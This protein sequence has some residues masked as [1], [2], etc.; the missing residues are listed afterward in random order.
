MAVAISPQYTKAAVA[1]VN[2][3]SN[4]ALVK[5]KLFIDNHF[6]ETISLDQLAA[7]VELN[8]FTLAK[9]FRL[10]F[11]VSP[12]R[13]LCEVRVRHAQS[14][15]EKGL[16]PTDIASEVGFFDQSH[17]IRHFKRTCGMTP[18]EYMSRRIR[19]QSSQ[20][21]SKPK[22]GCCSASFLP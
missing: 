19:R 6:R 20:T 21:V 5:A 18:R 14:L 15:M 17:L 3:N 16:R 12:H 4:D 9:R 10:H 2:S 22:P 1:A 13:Y 8:R 7:Y 11:G